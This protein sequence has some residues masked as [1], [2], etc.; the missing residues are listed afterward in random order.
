MVSDENLII[1][2][3]TAQVQLLRFKLSEFFPVF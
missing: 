1:K 2:Y 3:S